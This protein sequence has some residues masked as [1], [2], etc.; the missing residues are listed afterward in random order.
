[1]VG[2]YLFGPV[3]AVFAD[4]F[5]KAARQ[6]GDC[7]V[8]D[9]HSGSDVTVHWQDSWDDLCS[10]LPEGWKPDFVVLFLAYRTIPRCL[11]SAP[12]PII[13]LA[14]DWN[15]LWH[16]YRHCLPRCDLVLTDTA[17]VEAFSRLGFN[18]VR[19][20]NLFGCERVYLESPLPPVERNIDVLFVGNMQPAVQRERLAW[21]ARLG[22][23]SDRWQIVVTTGAYDESYRAL[24]NRAR[25]AFNRSIRGE[26]NRRTFEATAAGALLFQE[27][28]NRE[29]AAYFQDR[30]EYVAYGPD[31]LE[32]LLVYY[33]ENEDERR[34]IAKAG[35]CRAQQYG[36]AT[37]WDDALA[38]I[39]RELA[40]PIQRPRPGDAASESLPMRTWQLV[41]SH[42]PED[43]TLTADLAKA[44]V[45]HPHSAAI[46]H[47]LAIAFVHSA[48]GKTVEA[49]PAIETLGRVLN[50]DPGHLMAGLNLAELLL[51]TG[52]TELA[53]EQARRMLALLNSQPRLSPGGM[54]AIH[55]PLAYDFFR[56]EWE[57]AAWSHAGRPPQEAAAKLQLLR[58][59]LHML[60]AEST[61]QMHHYYEAGIARPDLPITQAALGGALARAGKTTEAATHLR[62]AVVDSPFDTTVPRVLFNVLGKAGDRIGQRRLARDRRLLSQAAP[63]VVPSESWFSEIRP[64]GDELASIVILC[65]NQLPYTRQ[66]LESVI[67]YT[68]DPYELLLIDNGSTDGTPAYLRELERRSGPARVVVIRNDDNRGFAAGCNQ[69]LAEAS[70]RYFVLLNND[71]LVTPGWLQGMLNWLLHDWPQVGMVGPVTN[72]APPPQLVEVDYR[73]LPQLLAFAAQR[74]QAF[75]GKAL[76]VQRLIGFCL[77][78]RREVWETV[79][80]LDES[81]GLG[82][83]E[84]DDFCFRASDAGF[85]LLVAL[86]VFIHHY[87]NCTFHGL[88]IDAMAHLRN[89]FAKFRAKWGEVRTAHYQLPEQAPPL[90]TI[91]DASEDSSAP[92]LAAKG[93]RAALPLPD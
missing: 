28:D 30:K 73:L 8:F 48:T 78:L 11:W 76:P 63:C 1:M 16:Y 36:F 75:A 60:L 53:A 47:A 62:Q 14:A 22:A 65:C 86:D 59:R 80:G 5:L 15:L 89:N 35:Q 23:L 39:S 10:R 24:L 3:D 70:G 85:D 31:N 4:Q 32:E 6:R 61:K 38:T 84:D 67:Q 42:H 90:D 29:I 56:V 52:K 81:F 2:R 69:G 26:C 68:R 50:Q 25:I 72:R 58:W 71:T 46:R 21:L 92:A 49:T 82:F 45:P 88:D 51:A 44:V 79:G 93:H 27:A 77:L 7:Q 66:C 74:R 83:F 17:G 12:V 18:H 41:Q 13:G 57:R 20:A 43:R 9:F 37:L 19:R 33:L 40:S 87:G 54:D 91:A 64:V 34:M 55:L